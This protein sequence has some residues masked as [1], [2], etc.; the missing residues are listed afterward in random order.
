MNYTSSCTKYETT[1]RVTISGNN[2][3][4]NFDAEITHLDIEKETLEE[5]WK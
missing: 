4:I 3:K 2:R 5:V 1:E